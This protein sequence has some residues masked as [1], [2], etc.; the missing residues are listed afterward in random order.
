MGYKKTELDFT[1]AGRYE[2][3]GYFF[4]SLSDTNKFLEDVFKTIPVGSAAY[5]FTNRFVDNAA[6]KRFIRGQGVRFF[7]A[8]DDTFVDSKIERFS[9]INDVQSEV[10]KLSNQ[11][12]KKSFVDIDQVKRIEFTD[13]EVGIFSFDMASLGLV[14]VYEYYSPLLKRIVSGNFVKSEKTGSGETLFYYQGT[15]FVPKHKIEYVGKQ[16]GYYSEI[17]K[18]LV[19]KDELIQEEGVDKIVVLYFPE[20]EKIEKHEVERKQKLNKDGKKKFATTFKKCFIEIKKVKN[21]LPRVDIIVPIGYSAGVSADQAFWNCIQVLSICEK[22]TKS[23]VNYRVI[24]SICSETLSGRKRIYKFINL[25]NENQPLDPNQL[26]IIV[27]DMRFYR[28]TG[29]L[30]KSITQYDS[31]FERYMADGVSAPITDSTEI[32]N[33]YINYLSKQS[34]ESDINASKITDSK[35]V[36]NYALNEQ[37]ALTGYNNTIDLIANL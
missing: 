7:G 27:S 4:D 25:K 16:G 2:K 12:S 1:L 19:D 33:A 34:S 15:P 3:V 24:G 35:I 30:L 9:K 10:L 23:G 17:L 36:L 11:V 32:K 8:T 21:Q 29:F 13:K 14:R 6:Q 5:G 18:R 28:M 31:G 20:K 26:G 37:A 22:L